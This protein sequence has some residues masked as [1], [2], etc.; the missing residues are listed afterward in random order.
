MAGQWHYQRD[1]QQ[2]GPVTGAELKELAAAGKLDP[3]DVVRR[4]DMEKWLPARQVKGLF[5]AV[6][7]P[8]DK[9][10]AATPVRPVAATPASARTVPR[11]APPPLPDEDDD[12]QPPRPTRGG[13][14]TTQPGPW[15]TAMSSWRRLGTPAKVGIGVGLL[16]LVAVPIVV[17]ATRGNPGKPDTGDTTGRGDRQ[18]D[19]RQGDSRQGDS[20]EGDA[21]GLPVIAIS[22]GELVKEYDDCL[23]AHVQK[24]L[25]GKVVS[26]VG[27]VDEVR[28]D[29]ITLYGGLSPSRQGTGWFGDG[30][31][32]G[33]FTPQN[34]QQFKGVAKGAK[35][36]VRGRFRS[37]SFTADVLHLDDCEVVA[38]PAANLPLAKEVLLAC[39]TSRAV[40]EQKYGGKLIEVTGVVK[41]IDKNFDGFPLVDLQSTTDRQE[42]VRCVLSLES[43][44]AVAR[45]RQGSKVKVRGTC[46]GV[47]PLSCVELKDCVVVPSAAAGPPATRPNIEGDTPEDL[48]ERLSAG[49]SKPDVINVFGRQP[50]GRTPIGQGEFWLYYVSSTEGIGI[51]FDKQGRLLT[52]IKQDRK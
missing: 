47:K 38:S 52:A 18:G 8:A 23:Q 26:L 43:K 10:V 27:E 39:K 7:A 31:V 2:H 28:K 50:D 49:L 1:G 19:S 36:A 12:G 6:T 16:V 30:H 21:G 15:A 11:T 44:S 20:R 35:V 51:S 41:K 9:P 13:K 17:L 42:V 33:Y 45:L 5:P 46:V 37:V 4:E 22:A 40:L 25:G 48:L 24:E 14:A 29:S 34:A 3:A 32:F